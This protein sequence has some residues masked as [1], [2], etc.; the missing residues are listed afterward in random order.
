M[1]S[2]PL[3]LAPDPPLRLLRERMNGRIRSRSK[4]IP[5]AIG[6]VEAGEEH[7]RGP[8]FLV[9]ATGQGGDGSSPPPSRP[10]WG[11]T[12]MLT[13]SARASPTKMGRC[14]VEDEEWLERHPRYGLAGP[15]SEREKLDVDRLERMLGILERATGQADPVPM[16]QAETLFVSQLGMNKVTCRDAAREREPLPAFTSSPCAFDP[17]VGLLMSAGGW[18]GARSPD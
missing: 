17:S 15:P 2:P 3:P 14:Q 10:V 5:R 9:R 12:L 4:G 11:P 18:L 1:P 7:A 13:A 8:L 6:R 16:P